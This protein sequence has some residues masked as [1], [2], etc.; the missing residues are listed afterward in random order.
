MQ[1][2]QVNIRWFR[3]IRKLDWVIGRKKLI[4]L[5]GPGDSTKSSILDAIELAL[6]PRWNA[7]FSDTDFFG[8]DTSKEIQITVTV[9]GLPE[10]LITEPKFAFELRGWSD[11]GL[12]DEPTDDESVLSVQL[13]VNSSLEPE[14]KVVTDRNPDGRLISHRDRES[15]GIARLGQATDWHL[16]WTKRSLLSRLTGEIDEFPSILAAASRNAR[17]SASKS[18]ISELQPAALRLEKAAGRIGVAPRTRFEARMDVQAFVVGTS[19]ITLH[20]GAIPV[21]CCG[22]GTRRLLTLSAQKELLSVGCVTLVDEIEHGLEPH[23]IHRLLHVLKDE[24]ASVAESSPG[25][26]I[27]TTHSPVVVIELGASDL[28]LV[29][30]TDGETSVLS[31]AA[32]LQPVLRASPAAFL[33]RSILVGEG[34]TEQGVCR[35]L[36]RWWSSQKGGKRPFATLGVVAID[37]QGSSSTRTALELHRLGYRVLLLGDSDRTTNPDE[38][39]L[40][41]NGIEVVLWADGKCIEERLACDLPWEGVQAVLH[42]ASDSRGEE[43]IRTQVQNELAAEELPESISDWTDSRALREAI[44]KASKTKQKENGKERAGWF[45]TLELGQG[46]GLVVS[47]YL[48]AMGQTD[49]AKKIGAVRAWV[50]SCG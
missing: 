18:D 1:I 40:K 8:C 34:R 16:S 25:Q 44:G 15:L 12:C 38:T 32:D 2:R 11:N 35:A 37:G 9:G 36:D 24:D 21:R 33:A 10:R 50:D 19:A 22:T 45:K 6:S 14:W 13:I 27:M 46:L 3:G 23:R 47:E 20:D 4:C 49:F 5:V 43:S 29:R 26:T 30:C 41:N 39:V 17:D 48:V 7:A 31:A 28:A 42:L